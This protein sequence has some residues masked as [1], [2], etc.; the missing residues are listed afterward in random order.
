MIMGI[1]HSAIMVDQ[2]MKLHLA[3]QMV[4]LKCLLSA[5]NHASRTCKKLAMVP[6]IY[7]LHKSEMVLHKSEVVW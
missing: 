2:T 6:T 7:V 1:V 4:G 5:S 3:G